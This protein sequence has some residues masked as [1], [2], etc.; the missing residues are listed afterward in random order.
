LRGRVVKLGGAIDTILT[1]HAYPPS[2]ARLLAEA[3]ALAAALGSALKFD[4]VFT[5]QTKGDGPIQLLVA[6]VTSDGAIRAYAQFDEARVAQAEKKAPLLGAG[7]L[8]FTVDQKA[9]DERYQGVV[10]LEGDSLTEAF[11]VYFRQSEQIPTGLV[12]ASRQDEAGHW[13]A[14]CLM[15]QQMPREGGHEIMTDTAAVDDW[16][17]V[18]MLMQTC[19]PEELTDPALAAEDLLFRL[20]HEEGVRV[21]EAKAF[22][23]E[24]RCSRERLAGILA[25]MDEVE[26]TSLIVD[27][28]IDVT[29]QFCSRVYSFPEEEIKSL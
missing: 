7:T 10:A 5:V 3:T 27:A 17:R 18:M 15:L 24:C 26:R 14:G 1:Q 4:G 8:V 2:V 28:K 22:R 13:H 16:H 21:F 20:F 11:Q 29:C 6:D 12:V 23:H 9:S 25:S 19:T